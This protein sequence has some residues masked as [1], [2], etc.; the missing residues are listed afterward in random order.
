MYPAMRSTAPS[1]T[2]SSSGGQRFVNT[3]PASVPR[4]ELGARQLRLDLQYVGTEEVE[5]L[6]VLFARTL[7]VKADLE[8][9][10]PGVVP[11]LVVKLG[12]AEMQLHQP[13]PA[14]GAAERAQWNRQLRFH[15][16]AQPA[17]EVHRRQHCPASQRAEYIS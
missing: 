14:P 4:F 10:V 17:E 9:A 13:A 3:R 16:L 6:L 12:V 7:E 15:T 5:S 1:S 2:P 8:A 11:G